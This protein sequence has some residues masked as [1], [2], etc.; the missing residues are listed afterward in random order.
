MDE[1]GLGSRHAL[2]QT[3]ARSLA[4]I[5][6]LK[7]FKMSEPSLLSK[8]VVPKLGE[9]PPGPGRNVILQGGYEKYIYRPVARLSTGGCLD[10]F[11]HP[12]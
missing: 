2:S 7:A 10:H 9:F 11:R 12:F 6:T 1:A 8:P 5:E 3:H 4:S